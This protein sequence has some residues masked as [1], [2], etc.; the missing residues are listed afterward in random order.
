MHYDIMSY[1]FPQPPWFFTKSDPDYY[2]E[3]PRI[4]Q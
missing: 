1:P 3:K 4:V 2:E